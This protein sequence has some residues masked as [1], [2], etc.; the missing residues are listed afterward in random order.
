MRLND[1]VGVQGAIEDLTLE[2]G[3]LED[4]ALASGSYLMFHN[5]EDE[6]QFTV[7]YNAETAEW[8]VSE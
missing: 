7:I 3:S 1:V 2:L 5:D 8:F 6:L 4:L